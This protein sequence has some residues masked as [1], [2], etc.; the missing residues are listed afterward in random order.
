MTRPREFT[1]TEA[2]EKAMRLFWSQG[3]EATSLNDLTAAMELSKSS[4]YA[5]FGGKRE[6]FLSTID[7]YVSTVIAREAPSVIERSG[8][9]KAGI[10]AL[11][12]HFLENFVGGIDPRGCYL[13][14]CAVEMAGKDSS[15]AKRSRP[16]WTDSKRLFAM[17]FVTDKKEETY[18]LR[19]MRDVSLFI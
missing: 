4:L 15:C 2:L 7:F 9:G 16:G 12:R 14:N 17:P 11:F 10:E 3:Y 1:I 5:T 18:R 8:G 6:L 19:G 13:N